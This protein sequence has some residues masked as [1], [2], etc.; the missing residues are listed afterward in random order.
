MVRDDAGA[1]FDAFSLSG[2][3]RQGQDKGEKGERCVCVGGHWHHHPI[4]S[5]FLS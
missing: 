2:K 4:S 5:M 3:Y 1:R